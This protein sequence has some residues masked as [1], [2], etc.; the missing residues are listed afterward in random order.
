LIKLTIRKKPV[1]HIVSGYK[2]NNKPVRSYS[3][4]NGTASSTP[5]GKVIKSFI[6]SEAD[7]W[8]NTRDNVFGAI[9]RSKENPDI[10]VNV[11]REEKPEDEIEEDTD[12]EEQ[13]YMYLVYPSYKDRGIPNSPEV[14]S[15]GTSGSISEARKDAIALAKKIMKLPIEKIE[16]F[17]WNMV[18]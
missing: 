17:S 3:R 5:R 4:G 10:E 16:S 8:E 11:N 7:R 13:G 18:D 2:R 6:K 15:D 1:R 14:F 12:F 9:W